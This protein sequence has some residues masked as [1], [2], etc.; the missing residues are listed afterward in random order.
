MIPEELKKLAR[1]YALKNCSALHPA[2]SI[3][4][5]INDFI[6]QLS[7]DYAIVPKSKVK[8]EYDDA[9]AESKHCHPKHQIQSRTRLRQFE[10]LFDKSLFGE[11]GK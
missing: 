10:R 1:E 4:F 8:E 9:I 6:E 2:G 5:I 11:E 3:D 7:K